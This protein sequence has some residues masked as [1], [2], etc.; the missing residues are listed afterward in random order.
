MKK[1]LILFVICV[2]V[3]C[4]VNAQEIM[5]NH[6]NKGG[7]VI[8]EV[9]PHAD[10]FVNHD[11]FHTFTIV[12]ANGTYEVMVS[13]AGKQKIK[14][15]TEEELKIFIEYINKWSSKKYVGNSCDLIVLKVGKSHKSFPAMMN[16]DAKLLDLMFN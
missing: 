11:L 10:R 12:K 1:V 2:F 16:S 5:K 4:I 6:L 7:K 8:I 3:P 13:K 14:E 15:L 9:T